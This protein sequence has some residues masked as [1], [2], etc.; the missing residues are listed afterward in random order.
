MTANVVEELQR[1]FLAMST[2][3]FNAVGMLQRDAAAVSN[4]A[5]PF[6][7][8]NLV[9]LQSRLVGEIL[10]QN[11][12]IDTLITELPSILLDRQE[13]ETQIAELRTQIPLSISH[14]RN[15]LEE[16][17]RRLEDFESVFNSIIE[18]HISHKSTV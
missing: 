9:E 2:S 15:R 14:Q 5:T 13:L 10:E 7:D 16:L 18:E 3:M 1:E 4:K 17:R 12:R 8:P 11:K 6:A